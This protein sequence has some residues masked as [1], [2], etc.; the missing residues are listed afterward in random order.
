MV[1]RISALRNTR[2]ACSGNSQPWGE[3]HQLRVRWQVLH[4]RII[5]AP[6]TPW[7]PWGETGTHSVVYDLYIHYCSFPSTT[8]LSVPPYTRVHELPVKIVSI[9]QGHISQVS[10]LLPVP[11]PS[12]PQW[13]SPLMACHVYICFLFFPNSHLGKHCHCLILGSPRITPSNK[14]FSENGMFGR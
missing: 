6:A 1:S 10:S 5:S 12:L 7:C 8:P 4:L 9:L 11:E 2:E 3:M 14:D 13:T